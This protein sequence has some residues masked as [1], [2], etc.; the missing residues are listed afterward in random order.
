[1]DAGERIAG[2]DGSLDDKRSRWPVAL[3]VLVLAGC[4]VGGFVLYQQQRLAEQERLLL[5]ARKPDLPI[6]VT[7][8]NAFTGP[9]LVA[10]FHNDSNQMVEVVASFSSAG[11]NA[12][13]SW[14]LVLSPNSRQDFGYREGWAFVPGQHIRLTNTA[15]RPFETIVPNGR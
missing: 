15:Y 11:V 10:V 6:R 8:R 13:Q 7:Y 5:E 9:G 1:M 2:S 4:L 3:G 12:T 14:R